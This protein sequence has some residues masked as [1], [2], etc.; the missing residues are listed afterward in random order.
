[1]QMIHHYM[2]RGI[3]VDKLINLSRE[4]RLWYMANYLYAKEAG[5]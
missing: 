1:M 5:R 4:E 3:G 2:E